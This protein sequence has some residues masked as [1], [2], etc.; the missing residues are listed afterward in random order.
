MADVGSQHDSIGKWR[1]ETTLEKNS[2][3][4]ASA[5][6][7]GGGEQRALFS[8]SAC[9]GIPGNQDYDHQAIQRRDFNYRWNF[10][11]FFWF[12]GIFADQPL[13]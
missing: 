4:N 12:Q 7:T 13:Y 8:L 5:V 6:K 3:P 10:L 2:K 1:Y 11:S 9:Q